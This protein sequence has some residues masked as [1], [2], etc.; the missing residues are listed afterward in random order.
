MVCVSPG[1]LATKVMVAPNSPERLGEA[2]HDAGDEARQRERQ[3]DG[4]EHPGAVRPER[5][6][7]VFQAAV[8][9]FDRE[10]DR[11][12][13]QGKAHD[14]AGQRRAGPA[15]REHDAEMIGE[16][17]ADRPAAAE[18]DQQQI[19]GHDRRQHQ[20]QM[21]QAVQQGLAPETTCAPA[22]TPW[23]CRTAAPPGGRHDGDPQ[24][25]QDRGPFIGRKVEQP[26]PVGLGPGRSNEP[27]R[28]DRISA[29]RRRVSVFMKRP[30]RKHRSGPA[31]R[32]YGAPRVAT[33]TIK[34]FAEKGSSGLPTGN[35]CVVSGVTASSSL[36]KRPLTGPKMVFPHCSVPSPRT[37]GEGR[38]VLGPAAI[39]AFTRVFDALWAKR[40]RPVASG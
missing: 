7:G 5:R 29:S 31:G 28:L 35:A 20:R 40:T 6:G 16:E 3:R 17:H 4:Q 18:R 32:A 36:W 33:A 24:R 21:H 12:H 27:W 2:E 15:E 9:G 8:D 39:S 13:H 14:P 25:Q 22:A 34:H 37:R 23:R 19:A 11:P 30:L 38:R 10:P 26:A 1:M